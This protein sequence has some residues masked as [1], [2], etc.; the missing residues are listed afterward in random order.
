[1]RQQRILKDVLPALKENGLLIYSTC[2]YSTQENEEILDYVSAGF[3]V[4][5]KRIET[6]AQWGIIETQSSVYKNYGYRFYPDKV[7]GEGFFIA[8]FQKNDGGEIS[9]QKIVALKPVSKN[10]YSI[11]LNFIKGAEAFFLFNHYDDILA[12]PHGY[13]DELAVLQKNL[14]LKKAGINTASIKQKNFIPHHELAVSSVDITGVNQYE[15][16]Y[17]KALLYLKRKD[18]SFEANEKGWAIAM[19]K[20]IRLGWMKVL[21][22]RINNYYPQEWRILK[23]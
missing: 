1:M 4:T 11:A 13:K 8:A 10:D 16:D 17:E 19:Y 6:E 3:D 2:S 20:N 5:S 21:P 23:D 7:K 9:R 12:I 22:A 14:Y 18:F 15:L